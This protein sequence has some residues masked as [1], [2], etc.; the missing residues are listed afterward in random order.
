MPLLRLL[1][2]TALLCSACSTTPWLDDGGTAPLL[3]AS[4]FRVARSEDG[5]PPPDLRAGRISRRISPSGVRYF[6]QDPR[7]QAVLTGDEKAYMLYEQLRLGRDRP[8]APSV[9]LGISYGAPVG[10]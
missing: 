5:P 2:A 10:F 7:D 4:G 9:F 1:A 6:Y 3:V 8:A